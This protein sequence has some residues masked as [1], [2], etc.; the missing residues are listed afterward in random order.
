M[1]RKFTALLSFFALMLFASLLSTPTAHAT[2]PGTNGKIVFSSDRDAPPGEIY[3]MD[4][5]GTNVTR[6]TNNTDND[7]LPVWSPDMTKVAFVSTRGGKHEIYTMHADGTNQVNIT[8]NPAADVY[9]AWTP[10][11]TKIS[12]SSDRD[13]SFYEL[14]TMNPDGTNVTRLTNNSAYDDTTD[15]SPDG[16]KIAFQSFRDGNYEV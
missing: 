4:P 1:Y 5:D 6:L 7:D 13:N 3:S 16:T 14:Y 11:G 8:N 9:P 10:D 12:F 15:W 2:S